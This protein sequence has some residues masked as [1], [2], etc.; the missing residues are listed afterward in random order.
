MTSTNTTDTTAGTVPETIFSPVMVPVL[1]WKSPQLL[2]E[3]IGDTVYIDSAF[4]TAIRF[5]IQ[6]GVP[7]SRGSIGVEVTSAG[8]REIRSRDSCKSKLETETKQALR[9]VIQAKDALAEPDAFS[10]L[11]ET[12][13]RENWF[14]VEIRAEKTVFPTQLSALAKEITAA[15][16]P[17]LLRI[18]PLALRAKNKKIF[19]S[20]DAISLAIIPPLEATPAQLDCLRVRQVIGCVVDATTAQRTNLAHAL[21][22][23]VLL[24]TRLGTETAVTVGVS[25]FFSEAP[26]DS[27]PP[28]EMDLKQKI[29]ISKPKQK[30]L[31]ALDIGLALRYG[32]EN[33]AHAFAADQIARTS[34]L[35][36]QRV[37]LR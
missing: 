31:E 1:P 9:A 32:K 8:L 16:L 13:S 33:V 11:L 2:S 23:L 12:L 14:G 28:E 29:T 36:S 17:S 37:A 5:M 18:T 20:F 4:A 19:N 21:D 6:L 15:G 24:K 7:A 34:R 35:A 26:V 22:Q 25:G 30:I 3:I 10:S 27:I